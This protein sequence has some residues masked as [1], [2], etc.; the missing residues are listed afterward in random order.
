M[1][2]GSSG[3]YSN[4]PRQLLAHNNIKQK[5]KKAFLAALGTG[6]EAGKPLPKQYS[7]ALTFFNSIP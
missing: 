6:S 3:S 5:M 4:D 1:M 2:R 7:N